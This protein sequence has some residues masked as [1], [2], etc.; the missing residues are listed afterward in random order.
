MGFS[1]LGGPL[2]G[3][4]HTFFFCVVLA[5]KGILFMLFCKPPRVALTRWVAYNFGK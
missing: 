1:D 2:Q 5:G 4:Q 3:H